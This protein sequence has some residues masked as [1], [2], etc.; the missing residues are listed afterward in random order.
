MRATVKSNWSATI[1]VCSKC[2]KKL[3]GGFGEKGRTPLAKA[4]KAIG[5]GKKR[6]SAFGVIETRCFGICPKGAVVA[7]DAAHPGTWL[8]VREGTPVEEA[9]EL[10]GVVEKSSSS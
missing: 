1:L 3:K 2:T 8:L 7:V 6:K 4:L 5:G 9:A 10:L